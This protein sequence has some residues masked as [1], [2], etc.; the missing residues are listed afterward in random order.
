MSKRN[1]MTGTPEYDELVKVMAEAKEQVA[2]AGKKA[3][4][5]LLKSFFAAN[6]DVTGIG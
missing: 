2:K 3:V 5:A 1:T 4:A 6:P